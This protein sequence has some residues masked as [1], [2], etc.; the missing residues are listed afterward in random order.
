MFIKI[1][2]SFFSDIKGDLENNNVP[3]LTIIKKIRFA[4]IEFLPLRQKLLALNSEL[5][6][7]SNHEK[8]SSFTESIIY[9]FPSEEY[10]NN[11][12]LSYYLNSI[13]YEFKEY[14]ITEKGNLRERFLQ[15]ANNI[16]QRLELGW[17]LINK[18]YA[19]LK[20]GLYFKS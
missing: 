16:V 9:Y 1:I 6:T 12:Y 18:E 14:P 20:V 11:T 4:R 15:L 5:M 10:H 17:T 19:K 13:D 7:L 3:L 8:I 2:Y